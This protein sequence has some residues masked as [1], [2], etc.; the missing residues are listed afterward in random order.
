MEKKW[1]NKALGDGLGDHDSPMDLEL[2]WAALEAKRH[3]KKEKQRFLWFWL[4]GAICAVGAI[5][6]LGWG[7]EDILVEKKGDTQLQEQPQEQKQTQSQ[8]QSQPQEQLQSRKQSQLQE[9]GQPQEQIQS[10]LQKQAQLQPETQFKKQKQTQRKTKGQLQTQTSTQEQRELAPQ[11]YRKEQ[12]QS[13]I[14]AK[15]EVNHTQQSEVPDGAVALEKDQ[16][17]NDQIPTP[18]STFST[19]DTPLEKITA[20]VLAEKKEAKVIDAEV[21]N[22]E[23]SKV[24]S[25]ASTSHET[26]T[27]LTGE[28][29][30]EDSAEAEVTLKDEEDSQQNPVLPATRK[31]SIGMSATYAFL[32]SG[33]VNKDE[34]NL[35]AMAVAAFYERQIGKAFY[36]KTGLSYQQFNNVVNVNEEY[37]YFEREIETLRINRFRSGE[38]EIE[39]GFVQVEYRD[40]N[41]H[42]LYQQYRF[43]SIPVL[44]GYKFF[45]GKRSDL[46][47]E[48][49]L[50]TSLHSVDTGNLYSDGLI[51]SVED[52]GNYRAKKF[53][54][55]QGLLG[56]HYERKLFNGNLLF[57]GVQMRLEL[58]EGI[59]IA[60]V[61]SK[62]FG[63]IGMV[64]GFR[65]NL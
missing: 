27:A 10:Q 62:R 46:K 55:F 45:L 33:R 4:V 47:I 40:Q 24:E 53:G 19:D 22:N 56:V 52:I 35:D 43:V 39:E 14:K 54:I 3:P 9:Q 64:V 63:L 28:T 34:N 16:K 60:E 38:V 42:K 25:I 23:F 6:Y 37:I 58:N 8:A 44:I 17:I 49:G 13:L 65:T 29:T 36:F 7:M 15:G 21:L 31:G 1:H 57:A 48:T 11:L 61:Q 18:E 2:E 59:S 20:T 30:E 12:V 50:S 41:E 51:Q 26:T 5:G 32:T